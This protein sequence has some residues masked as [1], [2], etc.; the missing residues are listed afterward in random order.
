MIG[1]ETSNSL[2]PVMAICDK[3]YSGG[4]FVFFNSNNLQFRVTKPQTISSITTSIHDP[5]GS[6]AR[7]NED[8]CVI[9][10]IVKNMNVRTNLLQDYLEMEAQQQKS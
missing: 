4:D 3:Q 6:F 5:D 1:G 2:L 10:K 7:T 8:N 9:Y